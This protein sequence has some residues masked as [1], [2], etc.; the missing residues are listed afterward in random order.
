MSRAVLQFLAVGPHNRGRSQGWHFW[1]GIDTNGCPGGNR[2]LWRLRGC[3]PVSNHGRDR[4]SAGV[5]FAPLDATLDRFAM[6]GTYRGVRTFTLPFA[7]HTSIGGIRIGDAGTLESGIEL[8]LYVPW[9]DCGI[10]L[11]DAHPRLD[12]RV[13]L[14]R[15]GNVFVSIVQLASRAATGQR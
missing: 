14:C 6:C 4:N 2:V 13:G 1:R 9:H 10:D 11:R 3:G 7:T 5:A 8:P 15:H 12:T